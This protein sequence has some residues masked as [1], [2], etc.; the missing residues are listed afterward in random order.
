MDED[1]KRKLLQI[2]QEISCVKELSVV[3]IDQ[4]AWYRLGR[5]ID[6]LD[7]IMN[8]IHELIDYDPSKEEE[9]EIRKVTKEK[10]SSYLD[11]PIDIV[12]KDTTTE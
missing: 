9:A 8:E 2:N 1:K 10:F 11:L 6:Y 4:N 12:D 5:T 3:Y 7:G